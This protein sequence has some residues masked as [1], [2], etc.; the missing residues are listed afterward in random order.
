MKFGAVILAHTPALLQGFRYFIDIVN[1]VDGDSA[2]GQIQ[3]LIVE[4]GVGVT[5]IAHNFL[6][7]VVAPA[8]PVMGSD[9][10]LGLLAKPVQGFVDLP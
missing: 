1:L 9:H 4:V 8:R 3:H 10:H 7:S 5:L 2:I 6:N